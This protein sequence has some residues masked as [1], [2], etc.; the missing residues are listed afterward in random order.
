VNE[1]IY[2]DPDW[3]DSEKLFFKY[4]PQINHDNYFKIKSL[5]EFYNSSGTKVYAYSSSYEGA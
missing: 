2:D 5:G 4:H 3:M 1:D